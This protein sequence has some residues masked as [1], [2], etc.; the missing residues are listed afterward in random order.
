MWTGEKAS[1]VGV[2]GGGPMARDGG[3]PGGKDEPPW[4]GG[5]E[6]GPIQQ[7]GRWE[8]TT[9]T[10]GCGKKG[11]EKFGSGTKLKMGNPS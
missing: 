8:E 6:A 3:C 10:V 2:G 9:T 4:D 1:R 5:A 11:R 7:P